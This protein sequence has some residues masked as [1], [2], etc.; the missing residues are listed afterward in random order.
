MEQLK[1]RHFFVSN[2]MIHQNKTHQKKK[3]ENKCALDE[4]HFEL[5]NTLS[6]LQFET[7]KLNPKSGCLKTKRH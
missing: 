1:S 6:L 4:Q 2:N 5:E 3:N 7:S